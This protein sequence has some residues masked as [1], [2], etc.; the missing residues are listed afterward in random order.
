MSKRLY[1]N[2]IV[3]GQLVK[4]FEN[5]VIKHDY[6]PDEYKEIET[7][8]WIGRVKE[9]N[10]SRAAGFVVTLDDGSDFGEQIFLGDKTRVTLL[11]EVTVNSLEEGYYTYYH[12][13]VRVQAVCHA[14]G[15]G[16]FAHTAEVAHK[17]AQQYFNYLPVSLHTFKRIKQS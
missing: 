8:V 3:P 7:Y 5:D 6:H 11:E 12:E 15:K 13:G 9:C 14:D 17:D 1:P 4:I 10:G 16:G 2:Q